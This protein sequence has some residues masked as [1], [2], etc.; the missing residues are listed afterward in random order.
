MMVRHA[1]RRRVPSFRPSHVALVTCPDAIGVSGLL[2]E[3]LLNRSRRAVEKSS[4]RSE[5][6]HAVVQTK[7]GLEPAFV[8]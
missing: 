5:D 6:L 4:V 1:A 3:G 2:R 8:R 7:A